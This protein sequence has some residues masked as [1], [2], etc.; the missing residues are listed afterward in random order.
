[1]NKVKE[2]AW[3]LLSTDQFNSFS[4]LSVKTP[5]P[6]AKK[7]AEDCLRDDVL[8]V[9]EEGNNSGRWVLEYLKAVFLG[10]GNPWCQAFVVFR[11]IKAAHSLI[12]NIPKDFP[13]TGSCTV[14][15]KWAQKTG[16]FIRRADVELKREKIQVGD[17]AYFWFPN[18]GRWGHTGIVVEVKAD[19]SFVTVEGNT[20]PSPSAEDVVREGQGVYMKS[21]TLKSLGVLGGFMRLPY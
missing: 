16:Y 7:A 11:L 21:R 5:G 2:F 18:L 6:V 8:A 3:K 1:M 19:G 4:A 9:R 14:S 13:R 15:V 17:I 10:A 20:G 12:I